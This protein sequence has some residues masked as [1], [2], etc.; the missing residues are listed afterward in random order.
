M[1]QTLTDRTYWIEAMCKIADPVLRALSERR[2]KR[3]MPVECREGTHRERFSH[4]E[5]MGRLL[6]GMA[7]W[8]EGGATEGDEN[9]LR[10]HYCTLARMAV[11]A[12]TDPESPDYMNFSE[13]FQPIVDTAYLSQAILRAPTELWKKLDD[14][15]K[16]N[17]INA[18]KKTRSRKPFFMNW[19]LFSAMTETTL[20]KVG[21]SDWDPMRIDYAIKQH[22]QW[23]VGDGLY[24]DG[25]DYHWDYY[26]SYVIHPML[27][28]ILEHV[29]DEYD[30]WRARREPILERAQRYAAI[31]ERLISPEGTFPP[32]G[33]SLA[34]RFGALQ[35]LA[36]SAL[37]DELPHTVSPAQVRSAL[38]AVIRRS[39]EQPGTFTEE[40]W[41]TIGHC[42]QQPEIG[43]I[44]IST[45][46]LYMCAA[47]FLPLGLPEAHPFWSDP[48][49]DWTAKKAWS[50]R[51]FPIDRALED[52]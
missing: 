36:Q 3:S 37:R 14:R 18:L 41:L 49:E 27:V 34:Y 48:P 8:L 29:G 4:L 32:I 1:E 43:E 10:E 20:Y 33:R 47:V 26:N 7:P 12:G 30:E 21:E 25:P 6:A 44:Y 9:R 16:Q 40:G 39:L 51:P 28:D 22:D 19:L 15:V 23:Y 46:S 35:S 42:G 5:A 52:E 2:L 13:D 38:T 24:S 31:Q 17:V 45:G 11:D 50:G